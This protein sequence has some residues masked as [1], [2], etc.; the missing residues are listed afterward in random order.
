MILVFGGTTEGRKA[1]EVLEEGGSPYFYSTK[2][3][4]QDITL[5]HGVRIDGAL[6]EAAMMH[7]CTE[8]GIRM[9][10]DAAH[11]FA[12]LLHQ[13][14]A[15][16]ASAL[17]LPVVRFE[18][19]YPPCDPAITWIDDYTQIPRDIH[20]LLATTGVQSISKLKPL[21]ADG[22][23][24]FYR[25][26]NRPSSIALAL[27]QGATQAQLCYY[28][29]PND[30]PIKADAIL[31]KE[32]GLSGGFTEKTGAAKACG[33]RVI[34]IKRPEQPK[35]FIVV[36]GPY[37][38]RRMVEKLLPEFYPL[39]SGLT[40]GTCATA[41]AVAA[42]IRLTSGEM[43]AEVP[44]MLPNGETI[45]VAVSYGDDY[46][47]CIKEAGDDPDVTNGIEV[48]AQVTESDHFEILG[49]EGVGRFTL[50]G[51]DYPPGEAAINK[52]PREMIRQNLERLKIEDGRLKIVISVPQGAEIARR[53]FN[54]R[55]GI[56]GGISI[57]GVSG[58]VKPFSEEA[59]VDSIRK[60]M[61]VA[62]A[63]QSARVVINSG[64][65]S[66]RFVKALYPEL[67]QQAFVEYGN[68]IGETLKIAH[69][70]DIRSITLG[71]MIGK[72][73]K[74]AAGHLDTHSKR[75]TMDKAF[76]SE[77]LHE[78]HCDIDI[79]DITLAREIWERLSPEQQQ[80][81]AD[82][83]ISHCA[84]YCQPL[85]P[86]GELT[87]LLIADDGTILPLSPAH[88]PVPSRS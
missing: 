42:C 55:L 45:H 15:K 21:E 81:F 18:R 3:G 86:N 70:L 35:S 25:I 5:Q 76:I 1:V 59:F 31:L 68:Y 40:T 41:A 72:A 16:T 71:V 49:G 9:I 23:S 24:I 56:E 46:A 88:Q 6:D 54:P 83:I 4:E 37:G 34:A 14:I 19:I 47:A 10:V 2:T 69:E 51:F 85:L 11:P 30:I 78:A 22:I 27:K 65:K 62:K 53:T 80:D 17:S 82:V 79:S 84:A 64:G 61:T 67:P 29:D 66:E 39:H 8:H 28:D 26:L 36:D 58:I 77:M 12:A 43:P 57:I 74:L 75:A 52:A 63:S 50:P 48:R 32:S 73:V 13:T 7:F 20:S 44:V 38:L 87:I 60:C 33:M